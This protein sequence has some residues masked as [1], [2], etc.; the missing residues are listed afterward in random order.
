MEKKKSVYS[1]PL[2]RCRMMGSAFIYFLEILGP[3]DGEEG[4]LFVYSVSAIEDST[5]KVEGFGTIVIYSYF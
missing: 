3:P 4:G 2:G 5:L 1:K